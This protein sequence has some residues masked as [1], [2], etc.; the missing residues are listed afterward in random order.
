V[1]WVDAARR[2]GNKLWN[3][4]R[5]ALPYLEDVDIP[6]D[7]GYPGDPGPEERWILSRLHEVAVRVDELLEE[8]RFSDAY[9]QL[10]AFAW[11]EVFDW[12]LELAKR[13]LR[14]DDRGS[15]AATLGVVLRDLLKLFHPVIPFLTEELWSHLGGR[16]LLAGSTWPDP[17]AYDAPPGFAT[18][19]E[20][21][22]GL[23]RFR[24]EHGLA[25]RH[26]LD[27]IVADPEGIHEGWWPGQVEALAAVRPSW[28]AEL[29]ERAGR[30]RLVAGPVQVFIS[31]EGIVDLEA[32]RQ[33]LAK[34]VA[35]ASAVLERSTAKLGNP[36]FVDR[37]P[38]DIVERERRKAAE[39]EA[40]LGTLLAQLE[41]LG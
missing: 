29:P 3:A 8:Y 6:A 37:A 31:L 20:I 41:D 7:G 26:P 34:A 11:S 22:T 17:P 24:A 39:A 16:E 28:Q 10:Y 35:E 14:S 18:F 9:G 12:F 5:F 23:R 27:V 30:T 40:R 19:Q 32:E 13:P 4:A 25:P 38:A 15:V 21:V 1:E 36:N 33:R 2:F